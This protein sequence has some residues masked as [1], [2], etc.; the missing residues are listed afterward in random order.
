MSEAVTGDQHPALPGQAT[1]RGPL[2]PPPAPETGAV[3][4]VEDDR[5]MRRVQARILEPRGHRC[6]TAESAG[7]AYRLLAERSFD[8]VLCDVNLPDESGLELARH[9]LG[10]RSGTAV[11][12]VSGTQ[13]PEV[14]ET[15]LALGAY[16][17][18]TKPFR[19]NELLIAVANALRRRTLE[20]EAR[21]HSDHLEEL[22]RERTAALREAFERL[23]RS[24]G[25]LRRS[26][27]ETI[28]RL[29]RAVEFRDPETG[30]HVERM[31]AYCGLIA[32]HMNLHPESMRVASA[33]HDVGKIAVPDSIL[34]KPGGLTPA[35]HEEMQR[36]TTIGYELLRGSGGD[37]LEL[38]ARIA[39]THHE[40]WDGQGYPRGLQGEDIPLEGRIAAIAD[41]FDALTSDRVYRP[42]FPVEK[43]V[44][45]MRDESGKQFDPAS[46][47]LFLDSL[48]DVQAI[49][50]RY[51]DRVDGD[52]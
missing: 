3:L 10:E 48:D 18:L 29:S 1:R 16:G 26:R 30:H 6:E 5:A 42:A 23:E 7:E 44:E 32:G 50:A 22:V 21:Q 40:R 9:V 4:V 8:L 12:M 43:A 19:P 41:V 37:L 20:L 45:M 15:A 47:E 31:S 27:A 11:V 36:H 51:A 49:R 46:A 14:A 28:Q 39:W 25:Q 2:R 52:S 34:R 35:E 13:D 24:A 33:L 38:A 17:Y